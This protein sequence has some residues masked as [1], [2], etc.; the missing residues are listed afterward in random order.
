MLWETCIY[1]EASNQQEI[2]RVQIDEQCERL[3]CC[4]GITEREHDKLEMSSSQHSLENAVKHKGEY[5]KKALE[6]LII[7]GGN[8]RVK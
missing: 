4:P 1:N 8:K 5:I 2:K 3:I 6:F 7:Y